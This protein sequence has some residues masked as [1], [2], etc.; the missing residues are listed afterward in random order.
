[1]N[2]HAPAVDVIDCY[3]SAVADV[4]AD[5]DPPMVPGHRPLAGN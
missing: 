5:S 2:V 3:L 4:V 1:M